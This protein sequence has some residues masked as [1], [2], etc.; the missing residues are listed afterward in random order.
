M[1]GLGSQQYKYFFQS[2]LVLK[3]LY[4]LG[5]GDA[6]SMPEIGDDLSRQLL[7]RGHDVGEPGIDG[8]LGHAVELGR[9][10]FLHQRHSCIFL[11]GPKTQ[12]AV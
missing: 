12:G 8:T 11:D 5:P 2:A 9:R 10:G 6:Q 1:S 7:G 3:C 4:R